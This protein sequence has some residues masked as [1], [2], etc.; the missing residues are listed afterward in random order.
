MQPEGVITKRVLGIVFPPFVV[1]DLVQRLQC[2]IVA[3]G[4][5]AIYELLRDL[6]GLSGA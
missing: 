1:R 5:A 4:E 3:V 2:Q 6:R